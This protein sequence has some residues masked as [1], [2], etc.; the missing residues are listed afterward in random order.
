MTAVIV[1]A[2]VTAAQTK[3]GAAEVAA[4]VIVTAEAEAEAEAEVEAEVV[5]VA[6]AEVAA[7]VIVTVNPTIG[8]E[9]KTK[10]ITGTT[11]TKT[12]IQLHRV[13]LTHTKTKSVIS[14]VLSAISPGTVPRK[15]GRNEFS[16]N[17][18]ACLFHPQIF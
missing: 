14:A 10:K 6:K 3:I 2:A 4:T 5:A 16:F 1:E 7:T 17:T 8:G 9:T 15:T 18:S 12:V 11:K 13:H